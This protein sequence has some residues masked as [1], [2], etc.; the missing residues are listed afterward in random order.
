MNRPRKLPQSLTFFIES[1][2]YNIVIALLGILMVGTVGFHVTEGWSWS[3]AFYATVITTTTIGYGDF[4]PITPAGRLFAVFYVITAVGVVG[5]TIS[6]LATILIERRT[7]RQTSRDRERKMRELAQLQNHIIVCGATVLGQYVVYELLRKPDPILIV[8]EHEENLHKMLLAVDRFNQSSTNFNLLSEFEGIWNMDG[9][10]RS[11][12]ELAQT[13]GVHYLL[14]NPMQT[15]SLV[16]A[17]LG[18]AKALVSTLPDDRD[19]L[20]IVLTARELARHVGHN[21]FRITTLAT[22]DENISKLHMAGADHVFASNSVA[23][24]RIVM[25]LADPLVS[26]YWQMIT[27]NDKVGMKTIPVETLGGA[28]QTVG[29]LTAVHQFS[30]IAIKRGTTFDNV[31]ALSTI[32]QDGDILIV[33]HKTK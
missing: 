2:I 5:Y 23:G 25:A 21:N 10:T 8:S 20:F 16:L 18:Q 3:D 19:N 15:G 13:L 29:E 33:L 11:L 26:E 27:A 14:A 4:S 7:E 28:G 30:I 1:R 6:R 17:G 32:V 31:P 24:L 22:E 9:D 12:A